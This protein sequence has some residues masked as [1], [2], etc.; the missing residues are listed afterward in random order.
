MPHVERTLA[1]LAASGAR[2]LFVDSGSTDGSL[3]RAIAAGVDVV[4]IAPESYVPGRV[5]N[6]AMR[7]TRGDV[8]AF[9]NADAVPLDAD[10]VTRL[11]DACRAGAAASFGRQLPRANARPVTAA[12]H[13]RAFPGH[14]H[15]DALRHFFSMAASAVR[16]DAWEALPF[17]EDLRFSEDVDWTLRLRA[18]G[19]R[20]EYVPEARFEHSHDYDLRAMDRRMRGEGEADARIRRRGP[21]QAWRDLVRPLAGALARDAR[22]GTLTITVARLRWAAQRGRFF[23]IRHGA[24][25]RA[26]TA[27]AR[28]KITTHGRFTA[29]GAPEDEAHV[30]HILDD[31]RARVT[32]AFGRRARAIILLGSFGCGEGRVRA[33]AGERRLA[34]DLDVV[35]LFAER[36]AARGARAACIAIGEHASRSASAAVDVWPASLEE[37][38]DHGGRLLWVDASVRGIRLVAGDA[39]ALRAL[40]GVGGRAAAADEV[41]RLLANRAT[42]IALSR[43]AAEAN[44]HD[45][46]EAAHHVTKAWIALGDALL[47]LVDRYASTSTGRRDALERYARLGAPSARDV[48]EGYAWALTLRSAPE[49]ATIT[50]AELE[51]HAARL[52]GSHAAIESHRLATAR[53]ATPE[54]YA[55]RAAP[56]YPDLTDVPRAARLFAGLRAAAQRRIGW[57]RAARHPRETLAR[58]AVILAYG[59]D[60][61]SARDWAARALAARSNGPV[62]VSRALVAARD[63]AA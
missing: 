54:Q 27:G 17:D 2:V 35:V 57:G 26:H 1:A 47:L 52:W 31:V 23:G 49:R 3:E 48:A 8:V 56:L 43:L 10:A 36:R 11:V 13:A 25:A 63:I 19:L 41:G 28:A 5:L 61:A 29:S 60:R 44:A 55:V 50:A 51:Q 32:A 22:A 20:V 24:A 37:I 59:H 46:A 14:A 53:L 38:A 15:D 42:G 6:D 16:R 45:P 62:D 4:Q 33:E 58:A 9:V 30:R 21:P 34:S 7:R 40:D 18:L 12:D 39:D